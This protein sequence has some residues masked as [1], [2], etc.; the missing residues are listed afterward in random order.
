M[1]Q[2]WQETALS[3]FKFCLTPKL[4]HI[5]HTDFP[6]VSRKAPINGK[7]N[8]TILMLFCPL[9]STQAKRNYSIKQ[10]DKFYIIL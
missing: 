3:G 10:R 9:T 8:R 1:I 2:L 4:K 5:R 7:K 6:V